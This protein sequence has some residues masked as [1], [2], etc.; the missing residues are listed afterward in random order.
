MTLNPRSWKGSEEM[1]EGNCCGLTLLR[2]PGGITSNREFCV[3]HFA[4]VGTE[5][6]DSLIV[7]RPLSCLPLIPA[8]PCLLLQGTWKGPAILGGSLQLARPQAD[9]PGMERKAFLLGNKCSSFQGIHLCGGF[10]NPGA[11]R[12]GCLLGVALRLAA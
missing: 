1:E 3:I 6:L 5:G 7:A 12:A 11:L 10:L 9:R 8:S 4:L 2:S